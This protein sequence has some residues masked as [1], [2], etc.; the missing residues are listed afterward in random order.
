MMRV[1]FIVGEFP[2]LS[3]TF[4]I[5]QITGLLDEGIEVDIF[6][7][8]K[9]QENKVHPAVEKYNLLSR[10]YYFDMPVNRIQRVIKCIKLLIF[11]LHKNP[12]GLLKSLNFL[13]YKKIALSLQLFYASIPFL[14][15]GAYD[16]IHCHF[17][18]NGNLGVLLKDIGV[19]EGKIVTT[20]YGYDLSAMVYDTY[21]HPYKSLFQK[22]YLFIAISNN[23]H[24]RLLKLGCDDRKIVIH[25]VGIELE[26]F[27]FCE[28]KILQRQPIKILTLARLSE[29]K[30]HKYAIKAIN[31]VWQKHNNIFYIIA[32]DG[33]LKNE[34]E[35]LISELEIG[36]N[37]KFLGALEQDEYLKIY[38][39]AHIFVLPSV[40]ASKGDEEGTPVVLMEAQATGLPVISTFHSGIPEVVI[41]GK[42]GFLVPEKDVDALAERLEYLIEH[43]EIW[44]EMGKEGR[45]FVE[46]KYDIKKLNQQLVEIYQDLLKGL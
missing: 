22:G 5:S 36:N 42:S 17:G 30:G 27:R 39:E 14:D 13:K 45:K 32:G 2:A 6:A 8:K 12:W 37:V 9:R 4:I 7:H 33:P 25:H 35:S 23:F 20:F 41:H 1:A 34:L 29:K 15:R 10:T 3:E 31:R 44:P 43:P 26:K 28:R 38:Q 19:V 24:E 40:T 21:S 16:I 11:N 18:P 46:K